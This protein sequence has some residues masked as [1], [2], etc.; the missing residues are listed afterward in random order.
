MDE[1]SAEKI[2]KLRIKMDNMIKSKKDFKNENVQNIS[3]K[4]DEEIIKYMKQED[5]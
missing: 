5:Y 1:N 3:R 4:I 2:E